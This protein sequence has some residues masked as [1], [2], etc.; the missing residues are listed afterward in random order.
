MTDLLSAPVAGP[1]SAWYPRAGT[2]I[3]AVAEALFRVHQE[4]AA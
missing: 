2:H 1:W 4:V 3:L